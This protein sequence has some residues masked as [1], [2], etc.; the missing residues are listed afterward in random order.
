VLVGGDEEGVL[1]HNCITCK[2][3]LRKGIKG[4]KGINW[5]YQHVYYVGMYYT[6]V[7]LRTCTSSTV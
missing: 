3:T 5:V 1:Y 2:L 4:I 7:L 6:W